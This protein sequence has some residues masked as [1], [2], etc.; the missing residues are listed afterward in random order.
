MKIR[1]EATNPSSIGGYKNTPNVKSAPVRK[2]DK[3]EPGSRADW[4][5]MALKESKLTLEESTNLSQE[6]LVEAI[7]AAVTQDERYPYIAYWIDNEV[8]DA[9]MLGSNN[10]ELRQ[11]VLKQMLPEA[12]NEL[13]LN[14]SDSVDVN[15]IC[16]MF[17]DELK[18]LNFSLNQQYGRILS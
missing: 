8:D 2:H 9:D 18:Q 11:F 15:K 14:Q 10:V 7:V 5:E 4:V 3:P 16:N 6:E 13:V 1:I 17:A 12:E